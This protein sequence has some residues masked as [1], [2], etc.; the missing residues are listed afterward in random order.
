MCLD[1]FLRC[2]TRVRLCRPEP[3]RRHILTSKPR[4]DFQVV[5]R[6][7][8]GSN[9]GFERRTALG[10]TYDVNTAHVVCLLVCDRPGLLECL[11][12]LLTEFVFLF[13]LSCLDDLG[14]K[15]RLLYSDFIIQIIGI[16]VP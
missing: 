16:E 12:S 6:S 2:K 13:F 7:V 14:V 8:G 11:F 9:R 10:I 1:K 4:V 3:C 5:L 15:R